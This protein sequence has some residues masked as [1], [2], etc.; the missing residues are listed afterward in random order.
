MSADLSAHESAVAPRPGVTPLQLASRPAG[1]KIPDRLEGQDPFT[2]RSALDVL[3]QKS[4]KETSDVSKKCLKPSS[5][6][7]LSNPQSA[8]ARGMARHLQENSTTLGVLTPTLQPAAS[9][10]DAD[11]AQPPVPYTRPQ[12]RGSRGA[13]AR[14]KS[15]GGGRR[16]PA[17]WRCELPLGGH[18]VLP[19]RRGERVGLRP[20]GLGPS[21]SGPWLPAAALSRPLS[22]PRDP[23]Q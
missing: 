15:G 5:D 14:E 17:C 20:A 8:F 23:C 3:L 16:L 11:E 19:V 13:R 21:Q 10:P 9:T 2:V 7:W 18:D 22:R 4:I 12:P 6:P 1:T